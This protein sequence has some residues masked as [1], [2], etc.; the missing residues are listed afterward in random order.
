M[1]KVELDNCE[2]SLL[3]VKGQNKA[4]TDDNKELLSDNT[5]TKKRL[6]RTRYIAGA[7]I[8]S[9]IGLLLGIILVH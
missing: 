2:E 5:K 1:T 9:T 7:G 6:R 8:L 3:L 4:L